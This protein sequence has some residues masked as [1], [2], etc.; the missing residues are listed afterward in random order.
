MKRDKKKEPKPSAE[1]TTQA[2]RLA[3]SPFASP[4]CARVCVSLSTRQLI[5]LCRD[6][7]FL[8]NA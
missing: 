3:Y 4:P 5:H 8:K 1:E 2:A 6:A 7:C